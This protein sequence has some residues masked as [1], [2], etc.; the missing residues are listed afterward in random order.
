MRGFVP[1]LLYLI[2]PRNA[3][4]YAHHYRSNRLSRYRVWKPLGLGVVAQLTPPSWTVRIIDENVTSPEYALLP[5]PD[6]VGLT[7]FTA[8]ASRAYEL[9]DQFRRRGVTV[10]MGGIHATVRVEEALG[11]VDA[12]VSGE[13]ESSW[14]Q[15]LEDWQH[16]TL[17]RVYQGPRVEASAIGPARHDLLPAGFAFGSIQTTRGCPLN[18]SFCSVTTF[19]GRRFRLR[20]IPDVVAEFRK[21]PERR[22]LIVDD[23]LCGTAPAHL[24]RTK[25]LFRAMIEAD[26]RKKWICQ[27][28]LNIADDEELLDLA[29]RAGCFGVFIGYE[30]VTSEGLSEI[31]KKFNLRSA[32]DIRA[33]VRRLQRRGITVIGSFILGLDADKASAGLQIARAAHAYGLD[34][35]NLLLMTPLPGTP[36]WEKMEAHGRIVAHSFPDDWQYYTLC[37]PVAQYMH[38]SWT[39]LVEEFMSSLRAF[40]SR[41]RIA[42][43]CLR[44]V[45]H[46]R[47]GRGVVT[48]LVVNLLCRQDIPLNVQRFRGY[49]LGRGSVPLARQAPQRSSDGPVT[50]KADGDQQIPCSIA[51]G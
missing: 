12:V 50:S 20:P 29:A 22:V 44:R 33:S 25:G 1:M 32:A 37:M 14:G 31:N 45:L 18:C 46:A 27:A 42:A 49:D 28:T 17:K 15:L 10:A 2:N 39:D 23:N 5:T 21:I 16:G 7:A 35:L 13:A 47:S 34:G 9:S 30:S 8:Q 43:R 4:I 41:R 6:L 36:L 19:N 38:L 3:A 40:Y 48:S 11:Y 26:L 24:A 51:S